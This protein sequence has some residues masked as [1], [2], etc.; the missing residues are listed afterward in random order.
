M[1]DI[2]R[3]K[4]KWQGWGGVYNNLEKIGTASTEGVL[5][6]LV[7]DEGGEVIRCLDFTLFLKVRNTEYQQNDLK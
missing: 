2:N 7:E 4:E 3:S 5:E 6:K 1:N